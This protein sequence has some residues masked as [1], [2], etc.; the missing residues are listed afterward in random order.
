MSKES[1]PLISSDLLQSEFQKYQD[2][3]ISSATFS[4]KDKR[5]IATFSFYIR[6]NIIKQKRELILD[7]YVFTT[8]A[9]YLCTTPTIS[10]NEFRDIAGVAPPA[11]QKYFTAQSFLK[12]P[13]DEH[14][15]I[16]SED[17]ARFDYIALPFLCRDLVG[18]DSTNCLGL[19]SG[20]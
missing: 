13:R 9:Q 19:L 3:S 15:N 8:L 17:F 14:Q 16:N 11:A 20:Q 12:F 5:L 7:E 1:A 2:R 18:Y 10:Y 6:R 4:D